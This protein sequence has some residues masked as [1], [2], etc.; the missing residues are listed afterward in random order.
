MLR[1]AIVGFGNVAQFGHWP[2]YQDNT[3]ATIVAIVDSSAERRAIANQFSLHACE[4]IDELRDLRIDFVDICTP[5]SHHAEQ[6]RESLRNRWHVLCEK[7]L[8]KESAELREISAPAGIAIVP[9][10][11]WKYAPII[12]RATE[13]LR[14]G[15]I[16]DL[17]QV[18][19][20]VLRTQPA[21]S[22]VHDWRGNA[23]LSGGGI[24]MD[25]GWHAIYLA[26][27]WFAESP[28]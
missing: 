2:A 26:L 16:G 27:D 5:P 9:V 10:H 8:V 22:S 4:K 6:I 20:A 21:Y 7:P 25:H 12:R 15:A 11:N 3:E 1:G 24:V 14:S 18:E 28:R 17:R 19:N 13:H 23:A